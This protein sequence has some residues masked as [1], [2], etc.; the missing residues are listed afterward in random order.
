MRPHHSRSTRTSV[1]ASP[2]LIRSP[3]A[4]PGA[5]NGTTALARGTPASAEADTVIEPRA[6][7][8]LTGV[9]ASMPSRSKSWGFRRT[10]AGRASL[11]M[12]EARWTR[13]ASSYMVR[14]LARRRE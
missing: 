9:P 5:L 14:P 11:A 10:V 7:V 1:T 3:P 4:P 6:E 2:A 12:V 13:V 8:T